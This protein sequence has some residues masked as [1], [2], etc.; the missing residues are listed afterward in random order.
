VGKLVLIAAA[1]ALAAAPAAAQITPIPIVQLVGAVTPTTGGRPAAPVSATVQLGL[2]LNKESRATPRR[3]TWTLPKSVTLSPRGFT[4]CS[5]HRAGQLAC[6]RRSRVGTGRMSTVMGDF[7]DSI[8][9]EVAVYADGPR[10]LTFAL[11][12]PDVEAERHARLRGRTLALTVPR[13]IREANGFAYLTNFSLE[14]GPAEAN[15]RP[16][17]ALTGCPRGGHEYGVAVDL[18]RNPRKPA[19]PTAAA[20]AESDCRR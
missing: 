7:T 11:R 1:A 3:I 2:T 4:R 6:P 18:I 19:F 13:A 10:Q 20:T 17:A 14:L 12:S 5:P 9:Y 8:V 15:G 16:F